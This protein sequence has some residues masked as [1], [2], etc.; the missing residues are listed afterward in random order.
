MKFAAFVKGTGFSDKG[1]EWL[2]GN[3]AETTLNFEDEQAFD[4]FVLGTVQIIVVFLCANNGIGRI[5]PEP[6]LRYIAER[7]KIEP[8]L[9]QSLIPTGDPREL[10]KKMATKGGITEAAVHALQ[11][12]L[13]IAPAELLEIIEKRNRNLMEGTPS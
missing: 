4:T 13:N 8:K 5:D 6:H 12:N 1:Y 9:L 11:T 7:L 2:F 10:L 3:L